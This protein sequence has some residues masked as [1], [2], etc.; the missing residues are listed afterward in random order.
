MK[1]LLIEDD[2]DSAEA[3]ALLLRTEGIEVD[4]AATAG[5]ALAMFEA[6]PARSVD[7][8]MLDLML[9]DMD[10]RTLVSRLAAIAPLPAIIVHSAVTHEAAQEAGRAVGALAVLRKPTDWGKMREVL[11]QCTGAR[12]TPGH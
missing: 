8:L 12:A 4:W 10:A 6:D 11:G 1:L 9:P 7:V 3:M 2:A 5:E